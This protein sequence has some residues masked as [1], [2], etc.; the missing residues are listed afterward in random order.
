MRA[1][2]WVPTCRTCR[3]WPTETWSRPAPRTSPGTMSSSWPYRTAHRPGGRRT[4]RRHPAVDCGADFRLTDPAQWVKFYGLRARRHPPYG[5]P[6]LPGQR[7][8]ARHHQADRGARLLSDDRDVEPAARPGHRPDRWPRRHRCGCVRHLG[9][10]ALPSHTCWVASCSTRSALCGVGGGH[11]HVPEILQNMALLGA[12]NP[13]YRFTSMLAPI[14]RGI[15]A[16]VTA[17]I[18]GPQRRRS[19]PT[20][21]PT[22]TSRSAPCSQPASGP[23]QVGAGQQRLPGAGDDRRGRRS[24]GHHRHPRQPDQGHSWR[25]DPVDEPASACPRPPD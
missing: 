2:N 9:S 14:P 25:S 13:Q 7:R 4:R 11:R 22:P 15:L 3:S 16:V 18:E 20:P 19:R 6:E 10:C 12:T 24:T 23:V 21:I 1:P 17:P 5:L 8:R